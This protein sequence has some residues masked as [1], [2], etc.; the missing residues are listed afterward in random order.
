LFGGAA[1]APATAQSPV[2]QSSDHI[3]AWPGLFKGEYDFARAALLQLAPARDWLQ[4][5]TNDAAQGLAITAPPDLQERLQQLPRE[6]RSSNDRYELC[7]DPA[8]VKQAIEQARQARAEDETWPQLHYLWPQHPIVDWLVDRVI[9]LFGRHRVPVIQSHY[10]QA[11]EQAFVMMGLVP[12]RKGQP[13]LVDWQ[14]AC[15]QPGQPFTLEPYDAFV[16]RAGLKA[17]QLPNPG[18]NSPLQDLQA[19]LPEAVA[20]MRQHM[21]QQQAAFADEMQQR[22]QAAQVQQLELRHA[23]QLEQVRRSQ[24]ERRSRVIRR[25]FDEYR[26]WVEDTLSTEPEPYLQVLAAVCG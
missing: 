16:Q 18:L 12:N 26:Q 19:A 14:V 22:L 7:A 1:T 2:P 11:G 15:R 8:R 9:T 25:V 17:G 5:S 21:V 4:W 3:E 10:L 24:F 23:K 20:C 6:V 13:L